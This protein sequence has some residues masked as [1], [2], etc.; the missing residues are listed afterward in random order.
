MRSVSK[1]RVE[2]GLGLGWRD[3]PDRCEEAAVVEPVDPFESG[4]SGGLEAALRV[5]PDQC[6]PA[7]MQ[8]QNACPLFR[9][10]TAQFGESGA[11]DCLEADSWG[12]AARVISSGPKGAFAVTRQLTAVIE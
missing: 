9:A 8:G 3:A 6:K 11:A 4:I 12:E 10:V 5:L 2:V 1:G 7:S